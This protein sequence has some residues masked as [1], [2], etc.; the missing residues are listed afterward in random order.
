MSKFFEVFDLGKNARTNEIVKFP[1]EDNDFVEI[2]KYCTDGEKM[3]YRSVWFTAYEHQN[4]EIIK[5]IE[6]SNVYKKFK[7]FDSKYR[8]VKW[9]YNDEYKYNVQRLDDEFWRDI[10]ECNDLK[11]CKEIAKKEIVNYH[12]KR[13]DGMKMLVG[14][15]KI[16]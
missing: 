8:V 12:Y 7:L 13:K 5:E 3:Y 14:G 4:G 9:V 6:N 15:K 2:V 1:D 10:G 11:E 16:C